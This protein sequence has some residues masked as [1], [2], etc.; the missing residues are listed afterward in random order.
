MPENAEH[1]TGRADDRIAMALIKRLRGFASVEN[2]LVG[3]EFARSL[4]ERGEDLST[5][6]ATLKRRLDCHISHLRTVAAVEM[7]PTDRYRHA[8]RVPE[9][10]VATVAL[11]I[12]S[13]ATAG[14]TPRSTEH[15]PPQIIVPLPLNIA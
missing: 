13:F 8:R 2:D 9:A 4:L 10:N 7:D 14:L 6:S 11:A 12:V 15:A 3:M 5:E 1:R